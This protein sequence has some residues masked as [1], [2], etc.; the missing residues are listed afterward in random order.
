[1]REFKAD[2]H[3]HTVL[4]ACANLEMSPSRIVGM[5]KERSIDLIGITDHN[6]TLQCK[7]VKELAEE[8]GLSVLLGAEV[9]TREEVHCLAYFEDL[10]TL[11]QFQ[12]Y[13]D[14]HLPWIPFQPENFGYQVLVDNDEKII[15]MIEGYL[16][17]A[18]DQ[19]ID[20]VEQ[21]VHRLGG[22]FVPAHI[23]RPMFG[24][25]NQLGFLPWG[26][27]CDAMGIMRHSTEMD[28]REKFNISADI[29]VLK[30]SD[31]H[32]LAS[33]GSGYT[34][35]EVNDLS[36]AEIIKALRGIEGRNTRTV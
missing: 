34:L 11:G 31:A 18:L 16:N 27:E 5:A 22:L 30:S 21:E 29:P 7:L 3:I 6:S 26:L 28:I 35:F 8:Q 1:M 10:K 19:S 33:I 9:T 15:R 14:S 36:F 12:G 17:V 2:L 32:S 23:E 24:L 20:Q 4:S 25:F 13:L